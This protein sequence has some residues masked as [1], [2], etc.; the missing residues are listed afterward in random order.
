LTLLDAAEAPEALNFPR[1]RLHALRGDRQGFWA[2]TVRRNW[3][4]IFRFEDG[5]ATDVELIDYH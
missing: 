5:S 3:R 4:I 2:V 1:L